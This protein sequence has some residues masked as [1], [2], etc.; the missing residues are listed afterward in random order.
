M[1][2]HHK[3]GLDSHFSD[4]T[5]RPRSLFAGLRQGLDWLWS[6]SRAAWGL[7]LVV[8]VSFGAVAGLWLPRGPLNSSEALASM[9]LGLLVGVAA[10]LATRSRWAL[11]VAPAA[12][13]AALEIARLGAAG[14][15]VD[16]INLG[17]TYGI[18]AF[19]VGRA[20][21][22]LFVL[23]PMV[24]GAS[25]GASMARRLLPTGHER[26]GFRHVL[27]LG[28][29]RTTAGVTALGLVAL[30]AFTARPATTG[31][32]IGANGRPVPGSI[33]ELTSVDVNGHALS[34]MIRGRSSTN[35]VLL[36]LAGGPGGSELGAMRKHSRA[37]EDRFVVATLDQRGTGKSYDQLDPVSTL[38]L[39]AAIDDVIRVTNYLRGRF[40]TSKV[41][42][43]G[44]SWGTLLG[45]LAVKQN[46]SL[47]QAF[48]GVGQMVSPAETDQIFYDDTL[49]WAKKNHNTALVN[50]LRANGPPPYDDLLAYEQALSYEQEL[51]PY[52]HTGNSEGSGQMTE[53][54][55]V[56]EYS[57]LE[58]AHLL[59]GFLDTFAALYPQIQHV[60]LR[61]QANSLDVPVYLAQGAHEAPGRAQPAQ[62]WFD[63]LTAPT[64]KWVVFET[65]GH[66]PLWEQPEKFAQLMTTVTA[67]TSP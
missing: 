58:V 4:N 47:F 10:G 34:I 33:A 42:L 63:G 6:H 7:A 50:R 53:N 9:V 15:T 22:G 1:T 40:G 18:M 43:V 21:H 29:R 17:T 62:E 45:V 8:P 30:A 14:P 46:P 28:L 44:Q 19:I 66:R 11:P 3:T 2:L 55:F 39:E 52:D 25:V 61:T 32:I 20:V 26:R 38:T 31:A 60:D 27:G 36:F 5:T 59:G 64:K 57:L 67:E 24:L 65:S 49:A 48:V 41:Y 35:P 16:G 12:F 54:I 51:Y 13:V 56:E 23:L 37:L